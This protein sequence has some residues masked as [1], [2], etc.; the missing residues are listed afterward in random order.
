MRGMVFHSLGDTN[1]KALSF[2]TV[3]QVK[4]M[5]SGVSLDMPLD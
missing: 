3:D 4:D 5:S 1:E 2:T